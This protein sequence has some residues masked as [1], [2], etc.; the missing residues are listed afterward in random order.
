MFML[1]ILSKETT[2]TFIAVVPMTAY[3][4]YRQDFKEIA[5]VTTP[6]LITF[7][8]YFVC[9][10]IPVL[11]NLNLH[12]L[13]KDTSL[14]EAWFKAY[15]FGMRSNP[16]PELM[17]DPFMHAKNNEKN[18]TILFTLGIYIK[19]LFFPHPLTHDYYP[20]HP[21]GEYIHGTG[22]PYPYLTWGDPGAL[23]SLIAYGLLIFWGIKGLITRS[24][25]AYC[26]WFYLGNLFLVSN[27]V[28]P[29]GTFLNERFMY[30]P[31][32]GFVIAVAYFL[33]EI[34]PNK[35]SDR[36]KYRQI[37][38][39]ILGLLIIGYSGKTISRNTS[40]ENDFALSAGDVN[41]SFKSAKSN[42][43]AGLALV[44]ESKKYKSPFTKLSEIPKDYDYEGIN[45]S[46]TVALN[47]HRKSKQL[48]M[49][50]QALKHLTLS[51]NIYPTYIQP[52]LIMGNAYYELEDYENAIVYFEKCLKLNRTYEYAVKNLEHVGD[53][54]VK[55]KN[56]NTG[57]KSYQTLLKYDKTNLQRINTKLGK[58]YAAIGDTGNA[59]K[60]LVNDIQNLESQLAKDPKNIGLLV[61]LG[62]IYGKELKDLN[63][64]RM[65][66]E[67]AYQYYPDNPDVMQKLGVVYAML[68]NTLPAIDMF[69]K[70]LEKNPKNAHILMNIGIAY[71]NIGDQ[72][73]ADEYLKKAFSIDPSLKGR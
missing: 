10:R 68:G 1:S 46:D 67:Q 13:D 5:T 28:F 24:V 34:L 7:I 41:V 19:L 73:N 8:L 39:G 54:C 18:A 60:L 62:E 12:L 59:Q 64:S 21:V 48:G 25:W 4:F 31:S 71:R 11:G 55:N 47:K 23:L 3:F 57:I 61:R 52:M 70:A 33:I 40:W 2:I 53:L 35:I 16:V 9:M 29:V 65:Y 22:Q 63:K 20:W 66:L 72:V 56:Y 36:E 49:L 44:D 15:D 37:V 45:P 58:A 17:N 32:I 69:K 51:L 27:L 42:M 43:S 38:F 30:V 26:I 50:Q 14:L 6:L